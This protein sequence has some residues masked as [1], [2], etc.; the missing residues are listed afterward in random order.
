MLSSSSLASQDITLQELLPPP[1][2]LSIRLDFKL[3]LP[4]PVP[5]VFLSLALFL[6]YPRIYTKVTTNKI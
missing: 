4:N 3:L 2:P 1:T 6:L 5:L